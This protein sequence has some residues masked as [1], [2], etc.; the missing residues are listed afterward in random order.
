[1][2]IY[3]INLERS[4]E[5]R[6]S[7][8]QEFEREGLD[9]E[10]FRATDGKVEAPNEIYISKSEWG[11]AD[12]HIRVWRDMI[13]NGYET[14]L[15]FEDDISLVPNFTTELQKILE[16]LPPDWDYVNIGSTHEVSIHFRRFSEHL[17]IGQAL[18]THAYLINIRCARKWADFQPKY[19]K[20]QFDVFISNYPSKNF[21]VEKALAVQNGGPSVI[22]GGLNRT[23]DWTFF[24]NKWK[25]V[26]SIIIIAI[27][28]Y[29]FRKPVL[30]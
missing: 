30:G 10:F 4:P 17:M 2:H 15:I 7:A 13:E 1:M 21:H 5:R 20:S 8:L 24:M 6:E 14:A 29:I 25:I 3:C 11:C 12:S 9:V 23:F 22:G 18:N 19:F 26:V 16:E 27:C 28:I